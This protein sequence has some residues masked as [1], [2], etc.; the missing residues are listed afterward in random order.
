MEQDIINHPAHYANGKD[1]ECI[2]AIKL[3]TADLDGIEAVCIGNLIKYV[4]RCNR[5][6]GIEDLQKAKWYLERFKTEAIE[7]FKRVHTNE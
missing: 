3:I 5:K 1:I 7:N 4:W 2:D 6:N